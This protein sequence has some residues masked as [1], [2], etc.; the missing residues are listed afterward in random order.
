M[1]ARL[2]RDARTLGSG[3]RLGSRL[4]LGRHVFQMVHQQSESVVKFS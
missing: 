2:V 4:G 1:N 3:V